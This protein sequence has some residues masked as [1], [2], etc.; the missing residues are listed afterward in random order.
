MAAQQ[1]QHDRRLAIGVEIGLIRKLDG[2]Q[3]GYAA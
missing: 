1:R 3:T 2:S